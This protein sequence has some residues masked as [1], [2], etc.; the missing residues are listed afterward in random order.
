MGKREAYTTSGSHEFSV[1]TDL[2]PS[3]KART[4]QIRDNSVNTC[5][6]AKTKTAD[7]PDK[8]DGSSIKMRKLKKLQS[9]YCS[10]FVIYI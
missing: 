5:K 9:Y 10:T 6:I 7:A 1:K 4:I 8:Q 2:V 3:I